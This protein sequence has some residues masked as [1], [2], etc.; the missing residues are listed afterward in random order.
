MTNFTGKF[1]WLDYKT[2]A[3]VLGI[4]LLILIFAYQSFQ[5]VNDQPVKDFYGTFQMW[6]RW[7]AISYLRLAELGYTG[8]GEN[9]F[10][11][12]FF[13]LYPALTA[14]VGIVVR[15]YLISAFIVSGIASIALGLVF[16]ALVR[17]DHSEKTA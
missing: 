8:S 12:V 4:K 6:E 3:V 13:P 2:I 11:I 15:D 16:R 17:L 5:I 10:L 14:L 1:K 9:R 7:D